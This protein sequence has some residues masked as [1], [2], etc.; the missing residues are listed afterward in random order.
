MGESIKPFNPDGD[1]VGQRWSKW[2]CRFELFLRVKKI[3]DDDKIDNL[4][5]YAGEYVHEIYLPLRDANHTFDEVKGILNGIFNPPVNKQ[6]NIFKFHNIKQ[7]E[8]EPFD[9]FISR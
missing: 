9:D 8:D 1:D 7:F 2:L 3:G 6:M 4:L 5:Y